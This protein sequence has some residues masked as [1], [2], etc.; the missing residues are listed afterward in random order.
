MT[1]KIALLGAS[2][3]TGRLVASEL[4]KRGI[5]FV[6]CGRD[7]ENVKRVLD[8][9]KISA[10]VETLDASNPQSIE[11]LIEKIEPKLVITTVGPFL[12]FGRSVATSVAKS[13]ASYIDSSGE[14][15]FIKWVYENIEPKTPEQIF[16]P[17][18]AFEY[19]LADLGAEILKENLGEPLAIKVFY[20]IPSFAPS[21]GTRASMLKAMEEKV[22]A[23]IDGVLVESIGRTA[24]VTIAEAGKTFDALIFP[25]GE[26]VMVPRHV[27]ADSVESYMVMSLSSARMLYRAAKEAKDRTQAISAGELGPSEAERRKNRFFIILEGSSAKA[28]STLTISGFDAYGITAHL[29]AQGAE[30]IVA[31]KVQKRGT[32][33]PVEA[34]GKSALLKWCEDWGISFSI[35]V[36]FE[37]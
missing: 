4:K 20:Y 7:A 31:G 16:V 23:Y 11:S 1:P 3:Y 19:A 5:E 15:A 32:C 9:L 22:F 25:G 36:R 13:G 26:P 8:E 6:A 33:T 18:L 17:S 10:Q 24:S 35:S 14:Q 29:I 34:F 21:R 27:H 30:A 2:G 28:K 12:E 37:G